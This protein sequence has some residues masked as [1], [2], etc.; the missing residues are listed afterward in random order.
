MEHST[1]S[2]TS[3]GTENWNVWKFQTRIALLGRGVFE[4][5]TENL[6][7]KK[8]T[9]T[10]GSLYLKESSDYKKKDLNYCEQSRR[11]PHD[12]SSHVKMQET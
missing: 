7:T 6:P 8:E 1:P 12:I 10:D 2:I 3:K 11:W 4:A 9:N 5:V